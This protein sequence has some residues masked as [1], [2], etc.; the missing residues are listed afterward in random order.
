MT[1]DR[2]LRQIYNSTGE[3]R[4]HCVGFA[5]NHRTLEAHVNHLF[6][7]TKGIRKMSWHLLLSTIKDVDGGVEYVRYQENEYL[8]TGTK[9][10]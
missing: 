4:M 5:P 2:F 9:E 1:K 10:E 7:K 8:E 6:M 3:C